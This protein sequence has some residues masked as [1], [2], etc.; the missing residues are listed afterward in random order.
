MESKFTF[1]CALLAALVN[2]Y[3]PGDRVIGLAQTSHNQF[4]TA[5]IDLPLPQMP[6]F[7]VPDNFIYH[8]I[9]PNSNSSR[10]NLNSDLKVSFSFDRN[11][12]NIPWLTIYD[13]RNRL[14]LHKLVVTFTHDEFE[15]VRID[16]KPICK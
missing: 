9:V 16:Y 1:V 4:K 7:S 15:I 13:S 12:L 11:K 5:W 2:A 10:I 6:R 8:S 14:T 3:Q